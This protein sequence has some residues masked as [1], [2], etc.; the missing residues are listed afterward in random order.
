MT[1][2]IGKLYRAIA[3]AV[4]ALSLAGCGAVVVGGAV[5]TAKIAHDRRTTGVQVEDQ[6]I[7]LKAIQLRDSNETLKQK[8]NINVDVYNRQVLLTG[9]A[10][11][12]AI[13]EQ[14]KRDVEN[15]ENVRRVF[16]EV[17][18]GAESTWGEATSDAYLT[19]KVKLA[20]FNVDMDGFDPTRIKVTSSQGSVYLMGLVTPAEAD[21]ATEEVRYV[22]GVK[23]VVKLFEYVES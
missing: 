13:V 16:N 9:Q 12:M 15:I 22:S 7:F 21:A 19:A 5:A 11:E 10:A 1:T 3:L 20:L 8:T 14:F 17:I 6:A 4:L 23:R 18:V 2:G